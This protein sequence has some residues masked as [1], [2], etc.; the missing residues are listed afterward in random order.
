MENLAATAT[1][2]D[3]HQTACASPPF[4]IQ[5]FV[6]CF[7]P[8]IFLMATSNRHFSFEKPVEKRIPPSH[9]NSS[10]IVRQN[11]PFLRRLSGNL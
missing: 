10:T 3:G 11:E 4:L 5:F 7:S 1:A 9:I 2:F 8:L 6:F